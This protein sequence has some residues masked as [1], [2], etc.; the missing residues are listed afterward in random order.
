MSVWNW[1]KRKQSDEPI[2]DDD[3]SRNFENMS[4]WE[5]DEPDDDYEGIYIG[6]YILP[7]I[8]TIDGNGIDCPNCGEDGL[9]RNGDKVTCQ[10]CD[11]EYTLA[12]IEECAGPLKL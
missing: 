2:W 3:D 7:N 6:K 10:Y 12:E 4:D 1:V 8:F 9:L 5:K 11:S